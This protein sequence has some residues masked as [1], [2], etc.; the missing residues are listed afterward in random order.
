MGA[1]MDFRLTDE[2]ELLRRSVREFAY[3]QPRP[4]S[5]DTPAPPN[6]WI[7]W[8][9]TSQAMVGAT[10]LI[11]AISF[12]AALLPATS[13]FQAACSTRKRASGK[14]AFA[15]ASVAWSTSAAKA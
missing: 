3:S 6:S 8:S 14:R 2:Q 10:T 1:G 5:S 9:I 4:K 7:A 13:I 15:F 12:C 11:M